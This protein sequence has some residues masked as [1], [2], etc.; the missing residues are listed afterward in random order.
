MEKK[1]M[2]ATESVVELF[3]KVW[4]ARNSHCQE[5]AMRETMSDRY[6]EKHSV[7]AEYIDEHGFEIIEIVFDDGNSEIVIKYD[8]LESSALSFR[9]R[10]S[11]QP[12]R[13]EPAVTGR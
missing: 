8:C 5:E 3:Q 9:T 13:T 6:V 10:R 2:P 1:F 7:Y 11:V 12:A 4:N